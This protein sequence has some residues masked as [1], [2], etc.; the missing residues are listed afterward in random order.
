MTPLVVWHLWSYVSKCSF[1]EDW[2]EVSLVKEWNFPIS[3][4]ANGPVV[5]IPRCLL[6][7]TA[8][9]ELHEFCD[10]S[11]DAYA[12][13]IYMVVKTSHTKKARF[14][15]VKSFFTKEADNTL[16]RAISSTASS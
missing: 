5:T 11:K 14:V 6:E 12:A 13:V 2:D 1:N 8:E 16:F 15:M 7:G 10:A 9:I 3:D 4:L